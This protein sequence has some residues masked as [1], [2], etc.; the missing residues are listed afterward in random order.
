[1]SDEA[2][3]FRQWIGLVNERL[4]AMRDQ[5]NARKAKEDAAEH[6][7]AVAKRGFC[8]CRPCQMKWFNTRLMGKQ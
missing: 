1:M 4:Q 7:S 3:D 2:V 6:R 8:Q 5:E